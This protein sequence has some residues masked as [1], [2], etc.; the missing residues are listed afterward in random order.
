MVSYAKY[1]TLKCQR[2]G[3]DVERATNIKIATCGVC[4]AKRK[5]ERDA[6]RA[7]EISERRKVKYWA[8]K[9]ASRKMSRE[10]VRR[11]R[12]RKKGTLPIS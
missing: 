2:C 10:S 9:E 11:F 5:Q 6:L 1:R 7:D 3:I 8:D 12:A 4:K